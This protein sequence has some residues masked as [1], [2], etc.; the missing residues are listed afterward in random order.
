MNN[1]IIVSVEYETPKTSRFDALMAEYAA[2]K[3]CAD[4]TISH[5]KPLA[6][7]AEEA[8]VVAILTQL[9]TIKGYVA[10]IHA[11][12]SS[13]TKISA[14]GEVRGVNAYSAWDFSVK[15]D[16]L[17]NDIRYYWGGLPF[18]LEG[19]TSHHRAYTGVSGTEY[20]DK[21]NIL[22]NWNEWEIYSKLEERCLRELRRIIEHTKD[23]GNVQ[24]ERLERIAGEEG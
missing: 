10:Q 4:E 7:A 23:C 3:K 15:V 9:E 24:R 5:Y 18:N 17:T 1:S 13:V 12:D 8:M 20:E 11:L 21:Y 14:V 16:H 6:D 22:G 2:A 19:L